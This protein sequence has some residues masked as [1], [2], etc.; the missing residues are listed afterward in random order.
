MNTNTLF[1]FDDVIRFQD[2]ESADL[3][4][5]R[6]F[7][8]VK[9]TNLRIP[10][11]FDSPPFIFDKIAIM[12]TTTSLQN[13][14]NDDILPVSKKPKV[15]HSATS[16][17]DCAAHVDDHDDE[18]E[19]S[20]NT[21][22][23][24]ACQILA[25][26]LDDS[27]STTPSQDDE[28]QLALARGHAI[29]EL[30]LESTDCEWTL[31]STRC[32]M[33]Q[34][35]QLQSLEATSTL[36]HAAL[37]VLLEGNKTQST[38]IEAVTRPLRS[39][40]HALI[41][42][43]LVEQT[44]QQQ[45]QN[46]GTV[47]RREAFL[48]IMKALVEWP[49]NAS[50][51]V[52]LANMERMGQF[53]AHGNKNQTGD[54]Q[55]LQISLQYYVAASKC[56]FVAREM[57]L[58]FLADD[59]MSADEKFLIETI[60]L[61]ASAQVEYEKEE[62]DDD[63]NGED[64]NDDD[65]DAEA[66]GESKVLVTSSYMSAFLASALGYHDIAKQVL[67]RFGS[68]KCPVTRIHPAVWDAAQ[69]PP[70]NCTEKAPTQGAFTPRVFDN[71]IS[72]DLFAT[73]RYAFRP[74]SPYWEQSG[75]QR[76]VYYS[77]WTDWPLPTAKNDDGTA[78]DTKGGEHYV[79]SN[80]VEHYI[81]AHLLPRI[82]SV[83][84]I[85]L[86]DLKGF[87]WWVHTRPSHGANL[88]HQLH[89]DTDE[90]LLDQ[91][92]I[93][94]F[95]ITASVTYLT[96]DDNGNEDVCGKSGNP[97]HEHGA[98]ILFDQTPSAQENAET[99]WLCFPK[100]KQFMMFP[101]DLLHGVLPCI[102]HEQS[103]PVL[104]QN[105]PEDASQEAPCPHRL[106]FMVNFWAYRIPDNLKH[107][108]LYGPSGPFPPATDEHSWVRDLCHS[109]PQTVAFSPDVTIPP[110][111]GGLVAVSPAW[112]CL[113]PADGN[114]A[115]QINNNQDTPRNGS[116]SAKLPS[117][118]N[119]SV[120]TTNPS[121]ENFLTDDAWSI[122]SESCCGTLTLPTSGGIHQRFFVTNAPQYFHSTLFEK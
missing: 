96:L 67:G 22:I 29:L 87:E 1:E 72:D 74:D 80:A 70:M 78:V 90:A 63:G 71:A 112:D 92:G 114:N 110:M 117:P 84:N 17:N 44:L 99:A 24:T 57:A 58:Q 15:I 115:E 37:H 103:T 56:A 88:G 39:A 52:C 51:L 26:N 62:E 109:Y 50:A 106:T 83:S 40:A 75:Y 97:K 89:F 4:A 28:T 47:C 21:S 36:P 2:D 77:Y 81:V 60:V 95:P 7:T 19:E 6:Q 11:V 45:D 121:S 100:S 18:E 102:T 119:G 32:R 13:P 41:A 122:A 33:K 10:W 3:M 34:I 108:P 59:S 66:Y 43:A 82:Q 105:Q 101:G 5:D 68:K 85:K 111:P 35:N 23:F 55:R 104:D 120:C 93:V 91:D 46:D 107:R 49:A 65:N 54:R 64:E 12:T 86:S 73:L 9:Q 116:D 25:G 20:S 27:L 38:L 69:R 61:N 53:C 31:D 16:G 94:K 118:S 113:L 30:L 79:V 76:N 8:D 42:N 14:V 48:H 98:T